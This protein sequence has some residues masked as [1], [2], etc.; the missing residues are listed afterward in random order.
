VLQKLF[1]INIQPIYMANFIVIVF[2]LT[3]LLMF[4]SNVDVFIVDLWLHLSRKFESSLS[5]CV[6]VCVCVYE[7]Q[8]GFD[9]FS[10]F[11]Y[12]H[13]LILM[14]LRKRIY[15][16][17]ICKQDFIEPNKPSNQTEESRLEDMKLKTKIY[18]A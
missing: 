15:S 17:M 10:V 16:C 7:T 8:R 5:Q 14:R 3:V 4:F 12:R 11:R 1:S 13:V 2:F 6:C 18:N 9:S